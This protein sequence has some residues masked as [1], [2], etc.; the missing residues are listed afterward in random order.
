MILRCGALAAALL[1][2][3]ACDLAPTYKVP[4]VAVPVSYQDAAIW[5]AAQ[6]ADELPRGDWWKGF[7]DPDLDDL[8]A[9]LNGENFSLVAA[10]SA[11]DQARANAAV[12]EAAL[13]PAIGLEAQ[14][15]KTVLPKNG[16]LR[17]KG[18]PNFF[19]TNTLDGA[20]EYE[21]DFWGRI[22]NAV[23]AG[24]AAAQA[25][26]AQLAFLRLSLQAELANDY[27]LLRG[28][29]AEQDLLTHTVAAY[30]KAYDVVQNRFRGLIAS[31]VDV[32]RA[33]AQLHSAQAQLD[34]INGRRAVAEHAIATLIGVPAPAFTLAPRIARIKLPAIPPA[35]PSALLQRRPD[36]AAA[37]RE[38]AAANA[39]IGIAR[40][41]FYPD[42]SFAAIGGFQ[43][44]RLD[45]LDLPSSFWSLGPGIS[46]PIFE[47]GLLRARE[48]G[49]VAA[50]NEATA[51]YRNTVIGAFQEVADALSQLRWYGEELHDDRQTV[52]AAQQT[53][54]MAMA[55]FVDGAVNYLEVV[56]AQEQL[57]GAQQL[58]LQLQTLYWQSGVRL[59]RALGGGWSERDLPAPDAMPL[60]HVSLGE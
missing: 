48:A 44:P 53:L 11:F 45:L 23:V 20:L 49:A 8:E 36:I 19:E 39:T 52:A 57:L 9:R 42:I 50:F 2:L 60:R 40:A 28:L 34:D 38:V 27:L 15:A 46:L 43:R 13:L 32:S 12:A 30:Q 21:L 25:S 10:S 4:T 26:A 5:H 59:I 3:G 58:L 6:P 35:L 24:K 17:T 7:A 37:E 14:A 51:N 33:E 18:L 41:A 55:L 56:V 22:R 1:L 31:G 29:D 54:N 47:G 16:V